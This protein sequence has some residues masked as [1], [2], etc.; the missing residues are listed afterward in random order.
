MF[1]STF[2]RGERLWYVLQLVLKFRQFQSTFPRGERRFFSPS[3]S[4]AIFSFNPRSHEGNDFMFVRIRYP[5]A[6]FNPRSHEGNDLNVSRPSFSSSVFQSTFPRGERHSRHC[7][8]DL[9]CR[10]NPCSHEGNDLQSIVEL[11]SCILFQSTFP[12][13]ERRLSL[14]IRSISFM[15]QSTFPRG[16]RQ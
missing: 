8:H 16:E 9:L 15:F 7:R 11:C 3:R 10:F 6:G 1:Q 13:G 12:R 14:S 4:T 2:P 5:F